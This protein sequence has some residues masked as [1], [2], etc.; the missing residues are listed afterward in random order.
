MHTILSFQAL[1]LHN[2]AFA[3]T[4]TGQIVNLMSNDVVRFDQAPLF[5][6]YLWIGPLQA[7]AVLALLWYKIGPSSLAGFGVLLILI[8]VQGS[9]GRLF[10]KLRYI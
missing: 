1:S 2:S 8:P 7:V 3:K 9:M 5:L 4:T 10:S 6:H